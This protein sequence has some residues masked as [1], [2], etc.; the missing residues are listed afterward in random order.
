MIS[1]KRST[2]TNE[3]KFN[4]IREKDMLPYCIGRKQLVLTKT[5]PLQCIIVVK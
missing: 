4:R 3:S 2:T 1:D 5:L